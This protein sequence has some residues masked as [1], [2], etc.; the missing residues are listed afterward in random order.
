MGE[1]A[2]PMK[3][4]VGVVRLDGGVVVHGV[5]GLD[6]AG[7]HG[8]VGLVVGERVLLAE[9][10]RAVDEREQER[11]DR[12]GDDDRGEGQRLRQGIGHLVGV[13]RSV[14]RRDPAAAPSR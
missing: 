14:E 13:A 9:L 6:V 5:F 8:D 12:E 3:S 2:S 7:A 4:V 11:R 10:P 1:L